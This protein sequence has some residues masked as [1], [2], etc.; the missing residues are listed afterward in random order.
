MVLNDLIRILKKNGNDYLTN[1]EALKMIE[2][3]QSNNTIN[4]DE[5]YPIGSIYQTMDDNFNPNASFKGTWE[6]VENGRFLQSSDS[7]AGD[8]VEA[9]LP[10]AVGTAQLLM[11]ETAMQSGMIRLTGAGRGKYGLQAGNQAQIVVDTIEI[12]LANTAG[13][14]N[15]Y[16]NSNTV[17]PPAI[18]CNIW[19]RKG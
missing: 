17:Q 2:L 14:N 12:N 15:I 4:Y 13:D 6:R 5:I 11:S 1:A 8:K 16:G 3:V 18:K 7:G 9:G 10:N 19:I